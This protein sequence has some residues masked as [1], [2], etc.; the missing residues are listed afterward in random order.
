M[1]EKTMLEIE[2]RRNTADDHRVIHFCKEGN[3]Y[4]AYEFS[5]W[6]EVRFSGDLNVTRRYSKTANGE[7][8]MVGFPPGSLQKFTPEGV[9]PVFSEDGNMMTMTIP[10]G[11]FRED[12]TV[13]KMRE[14]FRNWKHSVEASN[15][16]GHGEGGGKA[17][18]Q[19]EKTS[20]LTAIM[21]KVIMYPIEHKSPI[22]CMGFLADIKK[23]LTEII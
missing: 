1:A 16:N 10:A 4:R 18:A 2:S 12:E 15:K 14:E 21:H 19:Q 5:A 13:E 7:I 9:T 20:C 22:E 11:R 6:L 17:T 8:V 23:Q 3:F